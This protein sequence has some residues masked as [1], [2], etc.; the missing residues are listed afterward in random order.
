MATQVQTLTNGAQNRVEGYTSGILSSIEGYGSKAATWAQ[1][2]L[3]RFFPPEQRAALLAKLQDFMLANP[4]LS[5]FLGMNIALTGVPLGLFIL[6]SLT[7]AIFALVVGISIGLLGA[8]LFTITCVG[9]ALSIVFPILFFTTM[10]ACFLFFWGLAGYYILKWLNGSSDSS[11]EGKPLLESG[12][13]GDSL[14]NLTGG[15]LTG[16]MDQAKSE[17]AKGDITGFSDEH[18]KPKPPPQSIKEEK[19]AGQPNGS[20]QPKQQQ[21]Q[22]N[23]GVSNIESSPASSVQKATKANGVEKVSKS[24]I[25]T[26]GVVKGGLSGATGLA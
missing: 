10:T 18:T 13:I 9:I 12:S 14:N 25:N 16:F 19:P 23:V 22:Q 4:K 3:D 20:A 7:V 5:T 11:G 26:A 8:A 2:L 15:R 17:K 1:D 24:G 21:K 6:F